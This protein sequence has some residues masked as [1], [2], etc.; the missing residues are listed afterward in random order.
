MHAAH[1]QILVAVIASGCKTAL[2]STF[3]MSS[4]ILRG[5]DAALAVGSPIFSM[6]IR[7]HKSQNLAGQCLT[8]SRALAAFLSTIQ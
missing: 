4:S 1:Q 6:G 7:C 2:Q 3:F 5:K 8:L